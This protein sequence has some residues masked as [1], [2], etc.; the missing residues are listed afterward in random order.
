MELTNYGKR[1]IPRNPFEFEDLIDP[2]YSNGDYSRSI[3]ILLSFWKRHGKSR[4][5]ICDI[6]SGLFACSFNGNLDIDGRFILDKYFIETSEFVYDNYDEFLPYFFDRFLTEYKSV[7]YFLKRF[8][9]SLD[10]RFPTH[11]II[12]HKTIDEIKII[13]PK[14]LTYNRGWE[15]GLKNERIDIMTDT[16]ISFELKRL[17]ECAT[18]DFRTSKGLPP[19]VTKWISEQHLLDSIKSTFSTLVV[20]GQGSPSWLDG[21]R[22]DIWLPELNAAIEYN[23]LQHYEPIDFFGGEEG[24]EATTNRDEAKRE[25]CESND[26]FLLEVKE[27]YKFE[28]VEEW[29]RGV[30]KARTPANS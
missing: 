21:Q 22:F 14:E 13:S 15:Y 12:N 1:K 10:W 17:V 2:Y 19:S 11:L 24:F 25:K 27:G 3:D 30:I 29:I 20:I 9:N 23:G 6:T 18:E 5:S 7:P 16:L 28:K 4:S 8:Y 26:T